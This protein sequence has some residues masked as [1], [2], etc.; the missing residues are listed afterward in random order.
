MRLFT[1]KY[2]EQTKA[3]D[4]EGCDDEEWVM[5]IDADRCISCG[6]CQMAC[7]IE[8]GNSID[9]PGCFRP[10]EVA[11]KI[12][13]DKKR[14]VYLPL[15]CR[16]CKLPCDYY[17]P[18]NFWTI[19]PIGQ[20]QEKELMSCDSCLERINEGLW[21]ACATTCS[22]KTIYFGTMQDIRFTLME[23]GLREM[24]KVEIK[25]Q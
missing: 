17:N 15:A 21:P 22:M 7:E 18:Y 11:G 16:H 6:A 1:S 19:C 5:L 9:V 10:I 25:G 12:E 14:I 2:F 20:E 8:H 4:L 3:P 23:K 24:G 13:N